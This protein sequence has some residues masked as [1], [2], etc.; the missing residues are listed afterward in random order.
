MKIKSFSYFLCALIFFSCVDA[1]KND[2]ENTNKLIVDLKN[3]PELPESAI[4]SV[5]YVSLETT[6]DVLVGMN[7]VLRFYGSDIYLTYHG[8]NGI[9]KFNKDGKFLLLIEHKG[10]SGEEYSKLSDFFITEDGIYIYDGIKNVLLQ[11]SKETGDFLTKIKI[12]ANMAEYI[13]PYNDNFLLFNSN[14]AEGEKSLQ[15]L[16]N[17][18]EKIG[19]FLENKGYSP[20]ITLKMQ[21]PMFVLG[22]SVYI[23]CAFDNNIYV[24]DGQT[25]SSQYQFDFGDN[26]LPVSFVEDS[27]N[28]SIYEELKKMTNEKVYGVQCL[29]CQKEWMHVVLQTTGTPRELFFNRKTGEIYQAESSKNYSLRATSKIWTNYNDCFVSTII[30]PNVMVAKELKDLYSYNDPLIELDIDEEA[31]PVVCFMKLKSDFKE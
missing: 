15:V 6:N 14:P 26:N 5:F 25:I 19:E 24:Y 7:P 30:A 29:S 11:Y 3:L 10:D 22:D 2:G 9:L 1:G 27:K 4:D 16:N 31:N 13:Q 18:G 21:D 23:T 28:K 8:A 20:G 17:N 12:Q